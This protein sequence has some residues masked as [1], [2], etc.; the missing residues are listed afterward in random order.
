MCN[1]FSFTS[2]QDALRALLRDMVDKTGNLQAMPGIFPD[3]PAP[4]I[5]NTPAGRELAMVRW[6]L[7]SSKKA[8]LEAATK[9]ANTLRAKGKEVDFD[10]LLK[11]EPDKD[12]T[13]VRNVIS[14]K[15][16]KLNAHWKPW[17][18]PENRCLVPVNSF[19]EPD[20][21]GGSLQSTWFALDE[22]RPL[23]FF[24]GIWV[25][26]WTS[27]RKIKEGMVT[28]DL[29]GFLTTAANAEVATV[30]DKAMPAIL[31]TA[32]ERE[33]WLTAPIEEALKLQRPLPDGSLKIVARGSKYDGA[34]PS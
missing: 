16:G 31:T 19:C 13:N 3:Y 7:P 28:I 17:L 12:T 15:T 34:D 20:Q 2:S 14:E 30:H 5:R 24:A 4:I 33:Q 6:G 9:R 32:E 29:F 23:A 11:M 8:I 18:G 21:V 22:T 25:P 27:V 1:L 10:E 26:Q